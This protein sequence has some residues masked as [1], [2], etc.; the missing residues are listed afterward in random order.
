MRVVAA[1]AGALA[2][3]ALATPARAEGATAQDVDLVAGPDST[4]HVPLGDVPQVTLEVRNAGTKPLPGVVLALRT[5]DRYNV[6]KSFGNCWTRADGSGSVNFDRFLTVCQFDG[7][8]APGATY[9]LAESPFKSA[10]APADWGPFDYVAT[11]Y[12]IDDAQQ[13]DRMNAAPSTGAFLQLSPQPAAVT[14]GGTFTDSNMTNNKTTGRIV[15]DRDASPSPATGGTT[16]ASPSASGSTPAAVHPST[17]GATDGDT[18][19]TGNGTGG[20]LPVTGADATL[21]GAAGAALLAAGVI[22]YLA[23]RRRRN[24]FTA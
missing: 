12:T 4:V 2:V 14:P 8:I 17:S 1:A 19:G 6:P 5:Y 20:G 18:G 21:F 16:S 11:W 13:L 15:I 23:A 10:I 7:V 3:I 9:R 22:V 24:T